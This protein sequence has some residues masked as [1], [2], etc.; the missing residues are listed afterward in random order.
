MGRPVKRG[1]RISFKLF[2]QFQGVHVRDSGVGNSYSVQISHQNRTLVLFQLVGKQN[3]RVLHALPNVAGLVS[4]GRTHVNHSFTGLR[5]HSQDGRGTEDR[6]DVLGR[7]RT[8]ASVTIIPTLHVSC[9][10]GITEAQVESKIK[11]TRWI[12]DGNIV[13]YERA[14]LRRRN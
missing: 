10:L 12:V 11:S 4:A 14:P 6:S 3:A 8:M 1:P 7:A 9:D 5:V 2:C 13:T